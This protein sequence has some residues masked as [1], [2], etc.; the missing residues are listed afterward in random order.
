MLRRVL[1]AIAGL[2]VGGIVVMIVETFGH[3]MYPPPPGL[4]MNNMEALRAAAANAPTGARA[5]V[6]VA[7]ALGSFAG[8]LTAGRIGRHIIPALAV[9]GILMLGGIF[10]LATIPSPIWMWVA[11]ILV[12]LPAAFAG[13]KLGAP[14]TSEGSS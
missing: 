14:R 5:A 2:I 1:A 12:F 9:G 6:V 8:G 7:W 13:G 10:N 4:D 3:R 11:G